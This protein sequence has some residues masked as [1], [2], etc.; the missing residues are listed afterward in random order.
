MRN[1][2]PSQR[3]AAIR[4]LMRLLLKGR[5]PGNAVLDIIEK[6]GVSRR[7]ARGYL[8][9]ARMCLRAMR[10]I[11]E[12]LRDFAG[13][14]AK[15]A[16]DEAFNAPGGPNWEAIRDF[17]RTY[18]DLYGLNQAVDVPMEELRQVLRVRGLII[19]Q[20]SNNGGKQLQEGTRGAES[21]RGGQ[22]GGP[23]ELDVELSKP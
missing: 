19:T 20:E 3:E 1:A 11:G 18:I 13:E 8:D 6:Y 4:D 5:Q 7:N 22:A 17:L 9:Q 21:V 16:I 23:S 15:A 2:K 14:T 10:A 12:D